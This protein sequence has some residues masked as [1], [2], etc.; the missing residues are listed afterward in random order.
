MS[1]ILLICGL[2]SLASVA[3]GQTPSPKIPCDFSGELL[4]TR[5][6]RIVRYT[7]DEMKQRATHKVDVNGFIKQADIKGTA[8]VDILVGTSGEVVCAKSLIGHPI[9][10]G[11]VETALR[12]WQFKPAELE[13][14]PVAYLGRLEFTLCNISCGKEGPSMTLLK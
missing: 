14:K 12:S 13:G 9:I 1:L 5:Q 2:F 11:P 7:S 8:I 4:R 6:G 3:V 10:R